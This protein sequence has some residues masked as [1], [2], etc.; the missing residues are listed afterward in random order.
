MRKIRKE[1]NYDPNHIWHGD[2]TM[3]DP[4]GINNSS[5]GVNNPT[6][7][8]HRS[9]DTIKMDKIQKIEA[10]LKKIARLLQSI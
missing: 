9:Q 8:W 2:S 1:S 7:I 3:D 4:N 5:N 10:I 6:Q